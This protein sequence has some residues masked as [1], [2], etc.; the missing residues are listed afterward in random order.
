MAYHF[1]AEPLLLLDVSISQYQHLQ[2][3]GETLAGQTFGELTYWEGGTHDSATLKVTES[4]SKA[5]LLP[6]FVYG[7]CMAVCSILYTCQQ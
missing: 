4:F 5:I 7:N 3:T 1:A 2:L 6:M